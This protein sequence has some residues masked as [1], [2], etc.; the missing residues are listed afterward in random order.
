[1]P[2][3]MN[4]LTDA[5]IAVCPAIRDAMSTLSALGHTAHLTGSGSARLPRLG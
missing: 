2:K 3:P 5:A 1:M 4:D